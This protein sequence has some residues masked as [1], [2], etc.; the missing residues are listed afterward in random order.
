MTLFSEPPA[1]SVFTDHFM[2]VYFSRHHHY[3]IRVEVTHH[4]YHFFF[5]LYMFIQPGQILDASFSKSPWGQPLFLLLLFLSM[6]VIWKRRR[7]NAHPGLFR[8][9]IITSC[10][11]SAAK[12]ARRPCKKRCSGPAK[13]IQSKAI[14]SSYRR[15]SRESF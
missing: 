15:H 12:L 13:L 9:L 8:E 2:A 6:S 10:V 1:E 7:Q 14:L 4:H 3:H 11:S 5:L